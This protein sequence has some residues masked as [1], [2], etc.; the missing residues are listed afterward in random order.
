MNTEDLGPSGD[1]ATKRLTELILTG[2]EQSAAQSAKEISRRSEDANDVVD[3]ISDTMNIVAD[4]HEVERYSN[5]QVEKCERAAERALEALRPKIRV[6]QA[7]FS[8]RVMVTSLEGDPHNFDK[9]LLLTMLQIG[10]FTALDGGS[11]TSPRQLARLVSD[12]KPDIL[13]V[14]LITSSAADKLVEAASLLEPRRAR[15]RIVAYGRGAAEL[16]REPALGIVEE[17]SLGALSRIAELL[18]KP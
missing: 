16:S 7:K 1:P 8:G 12:L 5:Q 14:P 18:M 15:P 17:D 6:E 10:G 9:T 11:D 2:D 13:A 4:L 3:A